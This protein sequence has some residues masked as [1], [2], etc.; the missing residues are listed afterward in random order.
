M[1][2]IKRAAW[3]LEEALSPAIMRVWGNPDSEAIEPDDFVKGVRA[4]LEAIRKPTSAMHNAGAFS[5]A[6]A[7][8][9]TIKISEETGALYL[10]G[11]RGANPTGM[12]EAMI[13]AALAELVGPYVDPIL[14]V[15]GDENRV[16]GASVLLK[17]TIDPYGGE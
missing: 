7:T 9:P 6:Q 11:Y 14:D 16:T 12:W 2:M 1:S 5:A 4:V 3:A 8:P 13:D 15:D 10:T 17:P